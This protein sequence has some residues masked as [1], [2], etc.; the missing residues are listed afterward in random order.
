MN[1]CPLIVNALSKFVKEKSAGSA[2]IHFQ[3]LRV[4]W[5]GAVPPFQINFP[6]D[7][8]PPLDKTGNSP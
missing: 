7:F 6:R 4:V 2:E 1:D 3:K 5:V 8:P